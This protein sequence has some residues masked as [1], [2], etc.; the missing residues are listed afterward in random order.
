MG[1]MVP[2]GQSDLLK[3]RQASFSCQG[4]RALRIASVKARFSSADS[5]L[6]TTAIMMSSPVTS[7]MCELD[8][9]EAVW[10]SVDHHQP[11]KTPSVETLRSGG[12]R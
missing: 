5:Q 4:T 3:G 6:S 9:I 12:C 8:R 2:G 7:T 1:T 10:A 11:P